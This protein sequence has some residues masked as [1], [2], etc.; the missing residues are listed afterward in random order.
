M[1]KKPSFALA[2]IKVGRGLKRERA[3][4]RAMIIRRLADLTHS[5]ILAVHDL[6]NT[7][8]KRH[9][10]VGPR[11]RRFMQRRSP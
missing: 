8:V 5:E 11:N 6:V 4:C 2:I 7:M 10:K 9:H 1:A 3:W